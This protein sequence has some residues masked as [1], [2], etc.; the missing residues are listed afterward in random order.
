MTS[1]SFGGLLI[2]LLLIEG[3]ISPILNDMG[4]AFSCVGYMADDIVYSL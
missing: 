2:A 1:L 3:Y 4:K